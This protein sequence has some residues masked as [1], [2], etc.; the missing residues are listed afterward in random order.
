M[1]FTRP[2]LTAIITRMQNDVETRLDGIGKLLRR[3]VVKILIK[4]LS[5]AIHLLY[6]F[7]KYMALQ[8][9]AATAD[10]EYLEIIGEEYGVTRTEATAATGQA[11]A[12]GTTG[13]TISAGTELQSDSGYTYTVDS[14][15][16]LVAGTGTIS[17]TAAVKGAD[18]NDD[19]SITL[20]FVSPITGINSTVTVDS[21]GLTGGADE[22]TD[23][24]YRDRILTRKRRPPHGGTEHDY[25]TW[26]KEISGVTRA[27]CFPQYQGN[28]TVGMAFVYDDRSSIVPTSDEIDDMEDYITEHS[29][30]ASGETIGI[31]VT[32]APGFEVVT[33][34]EKS[35]DFTITLEPNT[36]AV[37]TAVEEELEALILAE[38]GPGETIY[39]SEIDEAISYAAGEVR[40]ELSIPT[41]DVSA[42][43]TEV[44]VLGT[45]TFQ[46]FS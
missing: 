43:Y 1:A 12:T 17:L 4:A 34:T 23:S 46:S 29:D 6:G 41:A 9:F 2:T 32:A 45:V 28:G 42:G 40:H 22:E 13:L 16:T 38:G 8:L 11:V 25:V 21:D 20:T 5:G 18:S 27:W 24:A 35:V 36:T 31:P 10:T 15:V 30:P 7:Q 14:A 26:A 44:H 37:Q 39:I 3:S 19:G 33:L